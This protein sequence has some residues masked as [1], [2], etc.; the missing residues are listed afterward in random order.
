MKKH[1]VTLGVLIFSSVL[2]NAQIAT[3]NSI[4][5]TGSTGVTAGTAIKGAGI[6]NAAG[7]CPNN[8]LTNNAFFDASDLGGEA[9]AVSQN[10]YIEFP[11]TAQVGYSV[12]VTSVSFTS[13]HSPTGVI[14]IAVYNGSST[15]L[16]TNS[17]PTADV[18]EP[19]TIDITDVEIS[20]GTTLLFRFY[21]WGATN[22]GGNLRLAGMSFFGSAVLPITLAKFEATISSSNT[23][24]S[25]STSTE[26]SNAFFSIER[27]PD[28]Y[29]FTEIGQVQGAGDSNT[30]Q[31]YSFTDTRP[32]SGKNYYRLKQVD[33][34]G[35]YTYSKVVSVNFGKTGGLL[36][37]PMPTSNELNVTLDK[38]I[39]E[40]GQW[41]V[42][43][44]S[45]RVLRTG[46]FPAETTDY[47]L[48]A[49]DLPVGSF[50]FRLVAGQEVLV[51]K[52]W[53]G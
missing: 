13:R 26:R 18:C 23:F 45:G 30:P 35:K 15:N 11:I 50:V 7:I 36:L 32:H 37:S 44:I 5:G 1:W 27:S 48:N 47:Q 28:S 12:T 6:T 14:T 43:D 3:W 2:L 16:G 38:P 53:K 34:D 8:V 39:V 19:F 49:A 33:F 42:L 9:E 41:Q 46:M 31:D 21:G 40:D 22:S 51:K 4:S 25:F 20:S 52:F 10:E 24:L 29:R 17:Q